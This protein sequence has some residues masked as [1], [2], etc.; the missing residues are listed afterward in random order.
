MADRFIA[1]ADTAAQVSEDP[2]EAD[3]CSGQL[4][5]DQ[6]K[7]MAIVSRMLDS[8]VSGA[9]HPHLAK[10]PPLA[11]VSLVPLAVAGTRKSMMKGRTNEKRESGDPQRGPASV[12]SHS[13]PHRP[14]EPPAR[15]VTPDDSR[16]QGAKKEHDSRSIDSVV[17][18]TTILLKQRS[19]EDNKLLT[20]PSFIVTATPTLISAT[21]ADLEQPVSLL[22]EISKNGSREA[23]EKLK[24]E[25]DQAS[26]PRS[27]AYC[28]PALT[29]SAASSDPENC[30]ELSLVFQE[31]TEAERR[32]EEKE[33]TTNAVAD[34]SSS[35][36]SSRRKS[37][38]YSKMQRASVGSCDIEPEESSV[39][40]IKKSTQDQDDEVQD[41]LSEQNPIPEPQDPRPPLP[42]DVRNVLKNFFEDDFSCDCRGPRGSVF[43]EYEGLDESA[44]WLQFLSGQAISIRQSQ[45]F[46]GPPDSGKVYFDW[47]YVVRSTNNANS[48]STTAEGAEKTE[49]EHHDM[50][51][52]SVG[53]RRIS[54]MRSFFG[55]A[56]G[57][58]EIVFKQMNQSEAL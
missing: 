43:R 45:L 21:A 41:E 10:L 57:W 14:F 37:N 1:F 11:E 18:T 3:R 17:A 26:S 55:N 56:K 39:R 23:F 54:H 4:T 49:V 6:A 19:D 27:T 9:F 31:M 58:D 52:Y 7:N 25:S 47:K 28:S 22:S 16:A 12:D 38:R 13:S 30:D 36:E 2:A 46:P 5:P 51:C 48:D 53:K 40:V 32:E 35:R 42:A 50:I 29:D 33:G 34:R 24:L 15:T 20:Q 44:S 8:W